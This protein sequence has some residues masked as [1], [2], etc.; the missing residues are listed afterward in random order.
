M[1]DDVSGS[2]GFHLYAEGDGWDLP[3]PVVPDWDEQVRRAVRLCRLIDRHLEYEARCRGLADRKAFQPRHL[4]PEQQVQ[5]ITDLNPG[6]ATR[7]SMPE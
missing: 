7:N 4:C 5:M 3:L 6:C 1:I 2:N